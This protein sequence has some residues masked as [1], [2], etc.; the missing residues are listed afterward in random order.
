MDGYAA[1][2]QAEAA[3]SE[4]ILPQ[5]S[6]PSSPQT[7]PET[8]TSDL[9]PS[10]SSMFG[11]AASWGKRLQTEFQLDHFVDQVKKQSEEVTKAYTQDI[12]EFAQA[13]KVGATRG[14]DELSTR[15]T[16]LKTDLESEL[17]PEQTSR[18]VGGTETAAQDQKVHSQNMFGGIGRHFQV[19]ALMQQQEKA[20]RLMSKLGSDLEDLLRDA[21]VIEAPGSGSTEEQKSAARKIIYDRR[22]AQLAA[23]RESEDTYLVDPREM[24]E[25]KTFEEAF[26]MDQGMLQVAQLL[27]ENPAMAGIHA[28]LVSEKVGENEFWTRYFFRAWMVEQEEVRRK[29]LV[30]AAVAATAEDEFSWDAEEEDEDEEDSKSK[31]KTAETGAAKDGSA[32]VSKTMEPKTVGSADA[33]ADAAAPQPAVMSEEL[34]ADNSNASASVNK[35]DKTAGKPAAAA[36]GAQ[37]DKADGAKPDS[38]DDAWD[39]W[40]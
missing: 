20:K 39:E 38:N 10:F 34:K 8:N 27:A 37:A 16:Q 11:F 36:A 14:M 2:L 24:S 17:Q 35:A 26:V 31:G 1:Q 29:K 28:K 33:A 3:E 40:E 32:E 21:I 22:M 25:F 6:E 5:R 23:I 4:G 9:V 13:V 19:D 15:F 18:A 30:E 7:G 12:A